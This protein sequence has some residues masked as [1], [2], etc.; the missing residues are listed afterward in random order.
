M[1]ACSVDMFCT[2]VSTCSVHICVHICV[3]MCVGMCVDV[4]AEMCVGMR[5]GIFC[6]VA[7]M[8]GRFAIRA[9]PQQPDHGRECGFRGSV[10]GKHDGD[11]DQPLHRVRPGAD[12]ERRI[13][14]V[15]VQLGVATRC[16]D[17]Q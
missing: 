1:Q 7:D 6:S 5:V 11:L 14:A 16:C 17:W 3:G 2:H 15:L 9:D 13:D 10:A 8:S 4:S 12:R